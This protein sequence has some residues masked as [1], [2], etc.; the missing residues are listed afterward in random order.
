MR[1]NKRFKSSAIKQRC[2]VVDI[3]F[4]MQMADTKR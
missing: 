4:R 1:K 2:K 3:K